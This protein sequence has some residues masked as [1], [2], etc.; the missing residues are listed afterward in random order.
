MKFKQAMGGVSLTHLAVQGILEF[1][2]F[3]P[4]PLFIP[5]QKANDQLLLHL[6]DGEFIGFLSCIIE[7]KFQEI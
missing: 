7:T 4:A 6:Q 3:V 5:D 1:P 2:K